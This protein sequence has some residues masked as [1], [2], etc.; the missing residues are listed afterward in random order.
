MLNKER[1]F[2]RGT[3]CVI[4]GFDR[5]VECAHIVPRRLG[6]GFRVLNILIL[7]PN[8][9]RIFDYGLLNNEEIA[10]IEPYLLAAIEINKDRLDALEYLYF[11]LGLRDFPPKWMARTRNLLKQKFSNK[12]F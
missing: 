3:K 7:C 8:H 5:Y 9:H 11:Q 6:G 12:F 4:C 10:K 2:S 1:K